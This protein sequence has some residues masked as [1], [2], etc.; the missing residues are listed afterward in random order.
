VRHHA[1]V[2]LLTLSWAAATPTPIEY[3][4]S[5]YPEMGNVNQTWAEGRAYDRED[6]T[7]REHN[8]NM[9]Q[10]NNNI[11]ARVQAA[12]DRPI[13]PRGYKAE[14]SKMK[15]F[16]DH[17]NLRWNVSYHLWQRGA[18]FAVLVQKYLLY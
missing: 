4:G 18:R 13:S 3:R 8:N 14:D 2:P 7:P 11:D 1:K 12:L 9:S 6:A 5:L 15:D 16:N 10:Y 17:Q